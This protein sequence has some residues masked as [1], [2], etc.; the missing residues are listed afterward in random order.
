MAIKNVDTIM[1]M[2]ER[3]G[4]IGLFGALAEQAIKTPVPKEPEKPKSVFEIMLKK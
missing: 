4:K 2:L 1:K 3:I